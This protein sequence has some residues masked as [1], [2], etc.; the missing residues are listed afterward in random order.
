MA[1]IVCE[2][3]VLKIIDLENF[4]HIHN[5]VIGDSKIVKV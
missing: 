3:S 4:E 5:A 1:L 2:L